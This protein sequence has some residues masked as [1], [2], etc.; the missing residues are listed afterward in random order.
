MPFKRPLVNIDQNQVAPNFVRP[1]QDKRALAG[2]EVILECR[3]EGCPEPVIK[4]LKDGQNV[5]QC[6]DYLLERDGNRYL[7]IVPCAQIVDSGRFTCQAVNAAGSKA[8]TCM[9]IVA[10]APSPLPGRSSATNYSIIKSPAPP[11]TPIGPAAPYFVKELQN[12]P[13]KLGI[14]AMLECRVV[15]NPTPDVEWYKD[16]NIK[17]STGN[18]YKLEY[19]RQ[20]GICSLIVAMMRNE[21]AAEYTC[22]ATNNRGVAKTSAYLLPKSEYEDWLHDQQSRL[23]SERRIYMMQS[24]R[25][26]ASS[27]ASG[28]QSSGPDMMVTERKHF[29]RSIEGNMA[30][31]GGRDS[32]I[33]DENLHVRRQDPHLQPNAE[34]APRI[35]NILKNL[36][37]QEGEDAIFVSLLDGNPK[38]TI[39]WLK[40]GVPIYATSHHL[41]SYKD[42]EAQLHIRQVTRQDTGVYCIE[43]RNKVGTASTQASL[44]VDVRLRSGMLHE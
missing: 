41:I 19:D 17:L 31:R 40:N 14:D 16:D 10:P 22:M 6:P 23:T 1:L 38:P 43:A 35:S 2:Q 18:R 12:E 9:L 24:S 33:N 44:Q 21:D 4:W 15:G 36:R 3:L 8:T 37:L 27:V 32:Q 7:L 42:G 11:A 20:T 13:L 25:N 5:T 30:D 39:K 28:T 34:Y 29:F 26:Y